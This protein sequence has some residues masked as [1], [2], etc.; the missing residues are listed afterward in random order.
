MGRKVNWE[1]KQKKGPGRK[2]KKQKPP[3][4]PNLL[5][6]DETFKKKRKPRKK[7]TVIVPTPVEKKEKTAKKSVSFFENNSEDEDE[8]MDTF[9]QSDEE[10]K[11][12]NKFN[13]DLDDDDDESEMEED[14]IDEDDDD[15]GDDDL[16]P[17]EKAA[18]KSQ[19][20][21]AK[22]KKYDDNIQINVADGEEEAVQ[23]TEGTLDL[24]DIYQRIKDVVYILE[25]FSER[26]EK[27]KS[28]SDYIEILKKDLCMYYSY[29]DFLLDK[30]FTLFSIP[31][32]L[33]FF[34]SK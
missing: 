15:E 7:N 10:L 28:R 6:N 31:E 9:E 18:L 13:S 23:L 2:A 21:E 33:D 24:K 20:K 5:N 25:K 8:G 12:A 29:N 30:F 32:L 26:R 22:K 27:D 34:G 14:E 11:M 4:F 3:T 17:I 16:L 19:K 1:E